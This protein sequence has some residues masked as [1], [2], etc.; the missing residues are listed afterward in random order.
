MGEGLRV[1]RIQ[2]NLFPG[3][4][5]SQQAFLG[6]RF[7]AAESALAWLHETVPEL[8]SAQEVIAFRAL[9]AE[10][11]SQPGL[12]EPRA[13]W[14]NVA[15]SR[16]GLD[17]L[18]PNEPG[19][20]P[21][22]FEQ[23][24]ARRAAV[25]GDTPATW[26]F[27]GTPETEPHALVVI[28]AD[29]LGDLQ[30]AVAVH[31]ERLARHGARDLFL[32]IL[33]EDCRG[34]VLPGPLRGHEHFGYRD[35]ISA[36]PLDG[37]PG[38]GDF[39]LGY[40][41]ADGSTSSGGPAWSRD[42]S[43]I[44]FRR[45]RQDVAGFHRALDALVNST[46]L[47]NRAQV[48]AKLVGRWPSGAK[49]EDPI[50]ERD[51]GTA[52]PREYTAD[53]FASDPAGR[54]VPGFAHV[55]KAHPRGASTDGLQ[56]RLLR[57]GIPYGPPLPPGD[58]GGPP[59]DDGRDRGL[60]F[61]A[62]Q[63]DLGRQYELVQRWLNDRNLPAVATGQ[64]PIGGQGED[65]A[66]LVL[67]ASNA[68]PS[69]FDMHH[70]VAMT[71]GGYFFMPSITAARF[72]ADPTTTWEQQ[73]AIM[74]DLNE[75]IGAL[76]VAKNPYGTMTEFNLPPLD[77]SGIG[78]KFTAAAPYGTKNAQGVPQGSPNV[79]GQPQYWQGFFWSVGTVLN[80]TA[81][82]DIENPTGATQTATIR[83]SK[84]LRIKYKIGNS[85]RYLIVGY[86][87]SGGM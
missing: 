82:G 71:G 60:L 42:G 7:P 67:R 59:P 75:Q 51:P 33:G 49:L 72:L 29:T 48:G 14:V 37:S 55:R 26:R 85:D 25:L 79:Q 64:D 13:T 38:T 12:S 34:A 65:P 30:Q 19:T 62:C 53:D 17:L 47:K 50:A 41:G 73:E 45:L 46:G 3:F 81:G 24:M 69:T 22:A 66:R 1:D 35:G 6:L 80:Q 74:G 20:F 23:G 78:R 68:L 56:H 77:E 27:G 57:R 4:N 61:L 63:T 2:G 32:E 9:R 76:I 70:Y 15:F 8:T 16:A 10:R 39:V 11:A 87:G 5:K 40:P 58:G 21:E 86:E 18:R 83:V 31:R 28:A 36:P 52:A 54:R 84:A 44:V 43:Y